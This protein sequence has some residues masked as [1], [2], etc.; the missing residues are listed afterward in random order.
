MFYLFELNNVHIIF[1]DPVYGMQSSELNIGY[2]C[3]V[4][5]Y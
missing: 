2:I 4:C 1:Y 5:Y 3:F